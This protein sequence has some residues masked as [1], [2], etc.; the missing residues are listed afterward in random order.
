VRNIAEKEEEKETERKW[1]RRKCIEED[2]K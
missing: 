1:K 2:E